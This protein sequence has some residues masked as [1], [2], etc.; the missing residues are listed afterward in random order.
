MVE[1]ENP[2]NPIIPVD[3]K[4]DNDSTF[5]TSY[6]VYQSNILMCFC[7]FQLLIRV[8]SLHI[9]THIYNICHAMQ[10]MCHSL[11]VL[12]TGM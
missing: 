10:D 1:K 7:L 9:A 2:G 12:A 3:H 4:F 5:D 6:N 8:S 11:A